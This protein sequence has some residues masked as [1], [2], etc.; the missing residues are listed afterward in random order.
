[1]PTPDDSVSYLI[2]FVKLTQADIDAAF[3]T[4][5][6]V[7]IDYTGIAGCSALFSLNLNAVLSD[8]I[9]VLCPA[10][11]NCPD[12]RQVLGPVGSGLYEANIRVISGGGLAPATTVV[13]H[14]GTDIM[15]N[16]GFC[17]PPG[18][19]FTAEIAPCGTPVV[20]NKSK[21]GKIKYPL[22]W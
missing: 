9:A 11:S 15:L 6:V 17:V 5:G 1:M 8:P 4:G 22:E 13:F 10:E 18:A 16:A 12:V 20:F 7:F 19:D 2:H 14:A 21:M 3:T